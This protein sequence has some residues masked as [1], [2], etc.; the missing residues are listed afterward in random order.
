MMDEAA[1]QARQ[2]VREQDATL[3]MGAIGASYR[4]GPIDCNIAIGH[5]V[6]L[7][8]IDS[9]FVNGSIGE[10]GEELDTKECIKAL[11]VLALGKDAI[12][13]IM[14]IKQRIQSMQ[15]AKNMVADNPELFE[16]VLDRIERISEAHAGFELSA[17]EWY[18][19]NFAGYDFQ[20]VINDMFAAMMDVMKVTNDMPE[21]ES[22]KK[23]SH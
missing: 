2:E 1:E 12:K 22:K 15:I 10:E 13:P 4:I 8:E 20:E 21:G 9:P 6:L 16:R 19:A 7:H 18:E 23:N 11:Y 5:L 17:M 14:A 3:T